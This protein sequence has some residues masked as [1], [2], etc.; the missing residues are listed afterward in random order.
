MKKESTKASE[1]TKNKITKEKADKKKSTKKVAEAKNAAE[2]SDVSSPSEASESSSKYSETSD[3]EIGDKTTGRKRVSVISSSSSNEEEEDEEPVAKDVKN[4][5]PGKTTRGKVKSSSAMKDVFGSSSSSGEEE[6]KEES[7]PVTKSSNTTKKG[8]FGSSS[9]E[10]NEEQSKPNS[11]SSTTKKDVFGS[12]SDEGEESK[13]KSRTT[14]TRSS[15]TPVLKNARGRGGGGR[16]RG[17]GRGRGGSS[18]Q[19]HAL[20]E[21]QEETK[22]E[23]VRVSRRATSAQKMEDRNKTVRR[24]VSK[25]PPPMS[26]VPAKPNEEESRGSEESNKKT[27]PA[28]T[29]H[30]PR[31][32]PATPHPDA[33]LAPIP[34]PT[35][36]VLPPPTTET[37]KRGRKSPR[38]SVPAE[39]M[40][41]PRG[42]GGGA[43]RARGRRSVGEVR[44][45]KLDDSTHVPV[46]VPVHPPAR[47]PF[48]RALSPLVFEPVGEEEKTV[49]EDMKS[50]SEVIELRKKTGG[51]EA[52]VGALKKT[53]KEEGSA[54]TTT[55]TTHRL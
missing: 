49:E 16:G 32:Y 2:L 22:G 27:K 35:T 44:E 30:S 14:A 5:V 52:E 54:K 3:E 51:E 28:G 47:E 12:S 43:R 25:E 21:K 41:A 39:E 24:S 48:I 11:K 29:R 42:R 37:G 1:T 10:E 8:V 17:R 6:E 9:D 23:Q 33:P 31:R 40:V 20:T 13:S 4:V 34:E 26:G 53:G 46:P 50:R 45:L 36:P 15:T 19:A 7:K 55:P 18:A 38:A